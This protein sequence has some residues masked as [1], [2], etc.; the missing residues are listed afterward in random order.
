MTLRFEAVRTASQSRLPSFDATGGS[1]EIPVIRT[2]KRSHF[3]R[4]A[5]A[6]VL[7]ALLIF[8]SSGAIAASSL[9]PCPATYRFADDVIDYLDPNERVQARIRGI[10]SNHLNADVENLVRGQSTSAA[11][12]DLRFI[13]NTVPNHHRAMQALMRLALRDRTDSPPQTQPYTVLCWLERATVFSPKDGRSFLIL[14]IYHARLGRYREA[15]N[16]LQEADRLQPNDINVDYNL[17]L[18]HFELKDYE[19]ALERAKR[20]YAAGYPLP[21]LRQK[22]T[23]AGQWRE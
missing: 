9:E 3:G 12:G 13:L 10:E 5:V 23:Q 16:A 15:L 17:G 18:V 1:K 22:L 8:V 7:D 11:G 19:R 14:G 21:G 4:L 20:A 6:C 2:K